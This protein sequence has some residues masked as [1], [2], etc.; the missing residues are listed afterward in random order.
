VREEL[1][2]IRGR[3]RFGLTLREKTP[4]FFG[5]GYIG[6]IRVGDREADEVLQPR[7]QALQP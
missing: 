5:G 2:T 6:G 3:N 4:S 7:A 1:R